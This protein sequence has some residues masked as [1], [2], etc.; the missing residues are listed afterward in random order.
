M[1]NVSEITNCY[2]CGVCTIACNRKLISIELDKDGFY[3][4]RISDRERCT[5][6]GLCTKVCAYQHDD[7]LMSHCEPQGFAAWSTDAD[8]RHRCSS[9]GV[10]YEIGRSLMR[11]GY[12]LCGVRY[13]AEA[14]RA[15]HYIAATEEQWAASVGSKYIQS[16]TADALSKIDRK[17]RYLITGTP[18]QIDSLRRYLRT[19]H[20]EDHFVLLDFFCHGVPSMLIWDKY[21]RGVERHIGKATHVAWRDKTHGW[22]DSWAMSL[23]GDTDE[24]VYTSRVSQ[25]DSFY[26]LFLGNQ[27]LGKACYHDCK[28]KHLSSAAD[29]RI[30]DLWGTTYKDDEKGVSA[31]IALTEKGKQVIAATETITLTPHAIEVITEGQMNHRLSYPTI[32][33]PLQLLLAKTRVPITWQALVSRYVNKLKNK[34]HL[35]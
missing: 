29:I 6:C 9:G 15:E 10:G 1:S 24:K 14:N 19:F 22:H 7:V 4:P 32:M 20:A 26:Q 23:H 35:P 25:G 16:Y 8:I 27:C 18:C 21:I 13:N 33:R 2:G 3:T 31:L 5:D 17:G 28:Y 34:L 11:Q 12:L 30:G